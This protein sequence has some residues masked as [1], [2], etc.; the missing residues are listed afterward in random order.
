MSPCVM[1]AGCGLSGSLA[2]VPA[3]AAI[4]PEWVRALRAAA[5]TRSPRFQIAPLCVLTP[6]VTWY[7][8][9]SASRPMAARSRRKLISKSRPVEIA[10]IAAKNGRKLVADSLIRLSDRS[11]CA[12]DPRRSTSPGFGVSSASAISACSAS[13]ASAW[14]RRAQSGRRPASFSSIGIICTLP[15]PEPTG[16][17]VKAAG[18]CRQIFHAARSKQCALGLQSLHAYILGESNDASLPKLRGFL[19]F[20]AYADGTHARYCGEGTAPLFHALGFVQIR[21]ALLGHDVTHIIAVDHHRSDGHSCLLADRHCIQR[22]DERG[23]STLCKCLHGLND[24]FSSPRGRT[25]VCLQVEPRR[26]TV[27][28]AMWIMSHV[29]CATEAADT[30]CGHRR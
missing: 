25:R 8:L 3:S 20:C 26:A 18:P 6:P 5:A 29:R 23:Y 21:D 30:A 10:P 27:P 14:L 11:L 16:C 13:A 2:M 7:I 12:P 1:R 15:T 9:R 19:R 4:L 24:Q 17:L 22:L 28:A